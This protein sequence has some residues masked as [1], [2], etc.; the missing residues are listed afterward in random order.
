[1]REMCA[2]VLAAAL[3][4]GAI[5]TA[6]GLPTLFDSDQGPGRGLTAP[7]SSLERSVRA[8]A[9]SGADRAG[10]DRLAAA[11]RERQIARA[12]SL[13]AVHAGASGGSALA[14]GGNAV[15]KPAGAGKSPRPKPAPAP[16]PQPS[17]SPS[18]TPTPTPAPSPAPTPSTSTRDLASSPPP[19]QPQPPVDP[20]PEPEPEP[21]PDPDHPKK[22]IKQRIEDKI[23]HAVKRGIIPPPPPCDNSGKPNAQSSAPS[24]PAAPPTTPPAAPT[25]PPTTSSMP[26]A[27]QQPLPDKGTKQKP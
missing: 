17:P 18:P 1:M 6:M 16:T 8:P 7:P 25:T 23:T 4:T 15:F 9:R 12:A 22:T 19:S 14:A 2:R 11:A 26:A 13:A 5:S 24:T 21:E 20:T 3:M 10:L 27:P